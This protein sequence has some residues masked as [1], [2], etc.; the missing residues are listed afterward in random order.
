LLQDTS[1]T[2]REEK[3]FDIVN[4]LNVGKSLITE[5]SQLTE[6]AQLNL[7]AGRKAKLSTAYGAAIAYWARLCRNGKFVR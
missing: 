3:L 5:P 1:P 4:H 7:D 6:L 2:T